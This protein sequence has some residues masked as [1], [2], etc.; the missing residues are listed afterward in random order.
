V[1][2]MVEMSHRDSREAVDFRFFSSNIVRVRR[3]SV[4]R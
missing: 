3:K 1:A 4:R 2:Q